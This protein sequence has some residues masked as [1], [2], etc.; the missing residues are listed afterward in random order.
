MAIKQTSP[1]NSTYTD[2]TG[3]GLVPLNVQVNK[4]TL[5][6]GALT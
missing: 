5:K 2:W 4:Y 6:I 3:N 1:S